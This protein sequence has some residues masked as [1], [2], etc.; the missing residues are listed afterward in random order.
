MYLYHPAPPPHTTL[1]L[2][3]A[4]PIYPLKNGADRLR[5][6]ARLKH[7]AVF[8]RQFTVLN[9]RNDLKAAQALERILRSEEHTSELQS[10]CNLVCRLLL[11]KKNRD[12]QDETN[13]EDSD[14]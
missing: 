3:D 2:H 8:E 14:G 1:S 13:T 9:F 6:N 10:P 7:M 11:E 12:T 5:A 4:L